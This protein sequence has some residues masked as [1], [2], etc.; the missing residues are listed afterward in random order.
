M[1]CSSAGGV[2][3]VLLALGEA[4]HARR[5]RASSGRR[6]R[7]GA[8]S[9]RRAS[10]ASAAPWRAG[11]PA[12]RRAPC[13]RCSS[14]SPR[15]WACDA[16]AQDVVL[17]DEQHDGGEADRAD[18]ECAVGERD[19]GGQQRGRELRRQRRDEASA[20]SRGTGTSREQKQRCPPTST[21]LS[22]V[23]GH[24]DDAARARRTRTHRRRPGS[25]R[26]PEA[27]DRAAR[28]RSG[29]S[30]QMARLISR[31]RCHGRRNSVASITMAR[32]A[33]GDGRRRAE[34]RHREHERQERAREAEAAD[35]ERQQL[36]ADREHEQQP[37]ER[38]RAA[39]RR[40]SL[41]QDRAPPAST[42]EQ[43]V[44]A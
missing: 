38:E 33:E 31:F 28:R 40:A 1:S 5:P 27:F 4:E 13:V 22:D 9:S 32:D 34:Q 39:S 12:A 36:A 17:E 30:A 10:R 41:V 35:L 8:P 18:A 24:E 7:S 11:R 16:R 25:A 20:A 44:D 14:S 42:S 6:R 21:K 23:R 29:N 3:Q 43:Q 15:S 2:D 19:A 37:D 26:Q